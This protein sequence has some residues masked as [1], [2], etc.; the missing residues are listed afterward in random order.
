MDDSSS[1]AR[2]YQETMA[3]YQA[4][5]K[6]ADERLAAKLRSLQQADG[7]TGTTTR[8]SSRST[9]RNSSSFFP[10]FP[11]SERREREKEREKLLVDHERLAQELTRNM[12][13]ERRVMQRDERK[14]RR[15]S[16]NAL[17]PK[18]KSAL[19]NGGGNNGAKS[20]SRG[21]LVEDDVTLFPLSDDLSPTGEQEEWTW[22]P[23]DE[24]NNDFE[25]LGGERRR[26]D[27]R[28]EQQAILDSIKRSSGNSNNPSPTDSNG[29]A[30]GGR[31]VRWAQAKQSP[32]SSQVLP[33][34]RPLSTIPSTGSTVPT[35][36]PTP[37]TAHLHLLQQQRGGSPFGR[38]ASTGPAGARLSPAIPMGV[39]PPSTNNNNSGMRAASARPASP[40]PALMHARWIPSVNDY[41]A[42]IRNG[43]GGNGERRGSN[44]AAAAKPV[45]IPTGRGHHAHNGSVGTNAGTEE[46]GS[47]G[48][49]SLSGSWRDWSTGSVKSQTL[50]HA[51]ALEEREREKSHA[52]NNNSWGRRSMTPGPGSSASSR[53]ASANGGQGPPIPDA[54]PRKRTLSFSSASAAAAAVP[55]TVNHKVKE[56]DFANF[57]NGKT[58]GG[59]FKSTVVDDRE[60]EL[61]ELL[62][63]MPPPPAPPAPPAAR[64]AAVP[65]P[66]LPSDDLVLPGPPATAPSIPRKDKG[67]G[68][69]RAAPPITS[70]STGS[71]PYP[72]RSPF[73]DLASGGVKSLY[74]QQVED[75]V[76]QLGRELGVGA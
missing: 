49:G 53:Y 18:A 45:Q 30:S 11:G 55:T 57:A 46:N 22:R 73:V 24:K 75:L 13:E 27:V 25:G 69:A 51:Q 42:D 64:P 68:K 19:A 35:L 7:S 2:V 1:K 48:S 65:S 74:T 61:V 60:Q 58:K 41:A 59:K 52:N 72:T 34:P 15:G 12:E 37:H 17:P 62:A 5:V 33:P 67:K 9:R 56:R 63:S 28:R 66:A 26:E 43:N 50:A 38:A 10:S 3:R 31:K 40:N 23:E 36:P 14:R 71:G 76:G 32:S 39:R 4:L 44:A 20:Q 8:P 6:D 70:S 47:A 21:V 29:S 16:S 54:N